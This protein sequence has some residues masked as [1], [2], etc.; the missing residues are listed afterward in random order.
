RLQ[1]FVPSSGAAS[2]MFRHLYNYSH[3]GVTQLTEFFILHF[4]RFPFVA[5]LSDKLREKGLS[6]EDLQNNNEWA[7]IFD[8]ILGKEGLNYGNYPKGL[9][10]F[11]AYPERVQT[12]FEEH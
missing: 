9:V 10:S 5:E 3:S 7:T 8:Y 1:K 6:L 12:A 2:R 4:S 11:H